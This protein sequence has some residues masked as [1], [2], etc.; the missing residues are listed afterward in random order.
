MIVCWFQTN[1]N[2]L[3][4]ILQSVIFA[5]KSKGKHQGFYYLYLEVVSIKNS[6]SQSASYDL[7]DSKPNARATEL[8]DLYSFSPRD[9]DFII[10]FSEEYGSDIF[11]QI[12]QSIC[13]SIYGHELV[14][15]I[16]SVPLH[17]LYH[18]EHPISIEMWKILPIFVTCSWKNILFSNNCKIYWKFHA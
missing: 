13:P 18:F 10:K 3:T 6:K 9:L 11:R 14:K 8:S 17:F 7:Q 16:S 15:G 4:Y 12:I 1:C 5:G 2:F